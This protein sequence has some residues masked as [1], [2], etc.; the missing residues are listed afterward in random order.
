MKWLKE[1]LS[2][3]SGRLSSK[4]VCG[5]LGWIIILGSYIYCIVVNQE[6]PDI[7]DILIWAI[8]ALLGVDS[9]TGALYR[10]HRTLRRPR[11]HTPWYG[12]AQDGVEQEEENNEGD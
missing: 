3:K 5:M 11:H 4:R 6:L 8:V 12:Q 10:D 7:T 2:A 1:I 9:V